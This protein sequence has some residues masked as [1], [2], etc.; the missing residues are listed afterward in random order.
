MH[1][2]IEGAADSATLK[3]GAALYLDNC[4]ARRTRGG[5]GQAS[6]FPPLKNNS[7]IQAVEPDTLIAVILQGDRIP[8]VQE[9]CGTG[10]Q[11]SLE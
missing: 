1:L 11:L 8:A 2:S 6:A 10:F 7:A 3:Q 4:K 9:L 5:T